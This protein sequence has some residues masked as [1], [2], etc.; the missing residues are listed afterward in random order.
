MTAYKYK[1]FFYTK[2]EVKEGSSETEIKKYVE[3]LNPTKQRIQSLD[4]RATGQG[5]ILYS[6]LL[7]VLTPQEE[8]QQ[9]QAEQAT[10]VMP[11]PVQPQP[12]TEQEK[13]VMTR[14]EL[15]ELLKKAKV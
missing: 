14:G 11:P 15:D 6:I 4:I 2:K 10:R 1:E 8:A 13:V 3:G 5:E 7:E 12:A 9:A